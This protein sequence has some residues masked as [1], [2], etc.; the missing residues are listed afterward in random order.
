MTAI[1]DLSFPG[2]RTST[3][4][5][6]IPHDSVYVVVNFLSQLIFIFPLFL[7]MVMYANDF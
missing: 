5:S 3:A 1:M 4:T 7:G 2:Q 6:C